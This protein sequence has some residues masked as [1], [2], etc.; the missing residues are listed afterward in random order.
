MTNSSKPLLFFGNERL[1]TGV[2]TTA[3]A[4][5]GLIDTGYE[6]A[7][8]VVAQNDQGKSRKARELEVAEIA[9]EHD[10]PLLAPANLLKAKDEL[11]EFH[12]NHLEHQ[13]RFRAYR[14]IELSNHCG[15]LSRHSNPINPR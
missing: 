6:V 7:A 4:L 9:K 2:T 13:Q 14:D 8:V 10:I 3:P 5:R 1:A 15:C 12:L 11:A